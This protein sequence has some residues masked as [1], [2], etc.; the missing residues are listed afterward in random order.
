M[1]IPRV[2]Y[3]KSVFN[4]RRSRKQPL[5][6]QQA[7]RYGVASTDRVFRP[8]TRGQRQRFNVYAALKAL[9]I[10]FGRTDG[11][12]GKPVFAYVKNPAGRGRMPRLFKPPGLIRSPQSSPVCGAA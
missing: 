12:T 5:S 8:G 1:I 9:S 6:R 10:G 11:G 4:Y 3:K 2:C 7:P